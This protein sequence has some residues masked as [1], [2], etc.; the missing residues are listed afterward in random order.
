M[1]GSST[2]KGSW[3]GQ[4][5]QGG[6]RANLGDLRPGLRVSCLLRLCFWIH[7]LLPPLVHLWLGS[8][9]SQWYVKVDVI[10]KRAGHS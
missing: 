5:P 1:R 6:L 7:C 10:L 2:G 8:N 9:M 4:V 3:C